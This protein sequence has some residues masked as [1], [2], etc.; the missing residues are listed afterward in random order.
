MTTRDPHHPTAPAGQVTGLG[1]VLAELGP[2]FGDRLSQADAIRAQHGA[3]ESWLPEALPEAVIFARST[4]EVARVLALCN[5]YGVPVV[6]F[7]AGS[8]LEGQ[9]IALRG[10]ICLDLTGMDRILAINPED[11]D[12]IVEAGVIR[13]TLNEHLRRHGLFFPVDPGAHATLGGM[14]ST[15]ASGTTTVRYG[16]MRELVLGLTVVMADGTV[17]KTGGRARKSAAGYDLTHLFVGAEG[18]LGVITEVTLRLFGLPEASRTILCAFPDL[19]SATACVVAAMQAGLGLQRIELA[20]QVQM[21]AI[22]AHGG[23][24][25]PEAPTLWT[26]ITG[27]EP[28]VAHDAGFFTELAQDCGALRVEPARDHEDANRIWRIRHNALYATRA[29]RPGIKGLSTDVC[30]P[31]SRLPECIAEIRK[32]IDAAGMLAPL[33][34]HAGDGNFHLVLMFDPDDP[35]ETATARRINA[36]LVAIA[37]SMG[38]T[39]TGEHG[40]GLGK[41]PYMEAEHGPA[42][43]VMRRVK[44]ALDPAD[45]L[46]PGKIFDP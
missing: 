3:V 46:N 20:D 4:D 26:E 12:C 32:D 30:V 41:K 2:L 16:S 44:R 23:A 9:V 5:R 22:N 21:Q 39:A 1:A 36:R 11:M 37:Q 10:G 6:P 34:G 43:D 17:I 19:D 42:L 25:L 15:R 28:A 40:V 27:S 35:D 8:S 7:G 29:L 38:G 18:T 31:V 45:I 24:Q 33:M 14:A 13:Q